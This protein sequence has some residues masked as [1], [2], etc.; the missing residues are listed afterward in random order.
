MLALTYRFIPV[1]ARV[2]RFAAVN[3]AAVRCFSG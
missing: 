2:H 1:S 3:A